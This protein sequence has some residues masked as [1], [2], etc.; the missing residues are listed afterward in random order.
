MR[1][2]EVYFERQFV[3]GQHGGDVPE[4]FRVGM[5]YTLEGDETLESAEGVAM[6]RLY[7]AADRER[8]RRWGKLKQWHQEEQARKKELART[9]KQ[10]A[11]ETKT[12]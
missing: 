4:K 12:K 8:K 1:V 9:V 7:A 11:L 3:L 10:I 5:R 6:D 2:T